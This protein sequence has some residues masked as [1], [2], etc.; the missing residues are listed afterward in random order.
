MASTVDV[1]A[2]ATD[3]TQITQI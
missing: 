2:P 1:F 3:E